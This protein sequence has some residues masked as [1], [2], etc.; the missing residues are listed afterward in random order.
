MEG[1]ESRASPPP[2][3][4]V[5]PPTAD[6]A[7]DREADRALESWLAGKCAEV[8]TVTEEELAYHFLVTVFDE[9]ADED[10]FFM[11]QF[12]VQERSR[13]LMERKAIRVIRESIDAASPELRRLAPGRRLQR[14]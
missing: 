5:G 13:R 14:R 4:G 11:Q 12:F 6:A 8:G 7:A 1:E 3:G 10:Q 9:N 2:L